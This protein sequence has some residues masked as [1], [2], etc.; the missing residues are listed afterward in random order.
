MG[1]FAN[2]GKAEWR[3]MA[4][5]LENLHHGDIF[6]AHDVIHFTYSSHNSQHTPTYHCAIVL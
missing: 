5:H 6:P 4:K 3:K 2:F 1:E